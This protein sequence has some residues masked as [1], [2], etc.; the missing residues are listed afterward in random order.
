VPGED[1][2]DTVQVCVNI[3]RRQLTQYLG[4][5]FQGVRHEV[6]TP[7]LKFSR[8]G[9]PPIVDLTNTNLLIQCP[10]SVLRRHLKYVLGM[11]GLK[12]SWR[13]ITDER[14]RNVFVGSE[15]YQSRSRQEREAVSTYNNVAQFVEDC[16]LVIIK[17]GYLGYQNKAAAGALKEALLHRAS[18]NR[19]TWIVQDPSKSCEWIHSRNADVEDYIREYYQD[20]TIDGTPGE[21]IE[22]EPEVES[23]GIQTDIEE[24]STELEDYVVT[25]EPSE[26]PVHRSSEPVFSMPWDSPRKKKGWRS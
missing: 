7:L 22:S 1:A 6:N 8:E 5:E 13:I 15:S 11:K 20:L 16:D 25:D 19:I 12:F 3:Y 26:V 21:E 4:A 17:L 10:W 14:I 18:V 23:N 2:D 24:P 9:G